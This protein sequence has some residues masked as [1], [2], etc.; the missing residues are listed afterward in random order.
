[1]FLLF[2]EDVIRTLGSFADPKL[3]KESEHADLSTTVC[4]Q[5]CKGKKQE[6]GGSC[7]LNS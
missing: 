2:I 6:S 4:I 1:M 5:D 3:I 7:E